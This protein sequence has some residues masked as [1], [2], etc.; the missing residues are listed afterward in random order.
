[1]FG[2]TIFVAKRSCRLSWVEKT[3]YMSILFPI[4]FLLNPEL[5]PKA[6]AVIACGT[7][8]T[9]LSACFDGPL[10]TE[11][12][13]CFCEGAKH[14]DFS[15]CVSD[16]LQGHYETLPC[17]ENTVFIPINIWRTVKFGNFCVLATPPPPSTPS[18]QCQSGLSSPSRTGAI[19]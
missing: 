8:L 19:L 15:S 1:M 4:K 12:S 2:P 13:K 6:L 3:F 7:S 10:G 17:F 16:I 11:T 9:F 18:P 5:C 14:L